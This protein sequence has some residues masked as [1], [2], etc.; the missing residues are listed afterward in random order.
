MAAIS[1]AVSL[2]ALEALG[3]F[4]PLLPV[5]SMG[6]VMRRDPILDHSLRPNSRGRMKSREY[7]VTYEINSVGLRDDEPEEHAILFLGDSF[8]EGYGVAR[9][10]VL[11]DL[12]RA[13]GLKVVNAGVKSYSPLL[14]YLYL[15]HRGLDLKPDTVVLLFDL[16]D[17]ANDAYYISRARFDD[18]GPVRIQPRLSSLFNPDGAGHDFLDAHS[19]LYQYALHALYKHFPATQEDIGYAGAA[20]DADLLFP[21]RDSIPDSAYYGRDWKIVLESLLRIRDLLAAHGVDFILVTYPYGHQVSPEAWTE[22]RKA[23]NFPPGVSSD[24][25]FRFLEKFASAESIPIVSLDRPF[26][27]HPDPGSLYFTHDGHWTAA[28]HAL[29]AEAIHAA[30]R[31]ESTLP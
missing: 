8:M 26:R 7:D 22:G 27:T 24:R 12:L 30:L 28:G 11:T 25:P 3:R 6:T 2:A 14:E 4:L 10:E 13:K 23:W 20:A 16:S 21:G 15:R 29:A 9:G 17:P 18:T 5:T 1:L 31:G 19:V